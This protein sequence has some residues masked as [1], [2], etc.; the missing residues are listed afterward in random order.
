MP[1]ALDTIE[2]KLERREFPNLTALE[3][4]FKRMVQNAKDYN[5][6]SSEIAADAERLRKALSNYM[7][8]TNPAY[9]TPGYVAIPTPIPAELLKADDENT[10]ESDEDAEGDSDEDVPAPVSNKRAPGRPRKSL[11][12]A[13]GN[14]KRSSLT[15]ALTDAQ[16]SQDGFSSLNFQ[17]AQEKLIGEMLQHTSEDDE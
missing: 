13:D 2:E 8:K 4:Y 17:Q 7:S 11:S 12:G 3:S 14:G 15:P 1:I 6:P 9:K 16:Y 5:E 10:G